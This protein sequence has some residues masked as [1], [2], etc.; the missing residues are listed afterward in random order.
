[1]MI[2][3]TDTK[4][5]EDPGYHAELVRQGSHPLLSYLPR[6]VAIGLGLTGYLLMT[7]CGLERTYGCALR[8]RQRYYPGWVCASLAYVGGVYVAWFSD[9]LVNAI[10]NTTDTEEI[11][12]PA[13]F[14]LLLMLSGGVAVSKNLTAYNA[15]SRNS[16][17]KTRKG[18]GIKAPQAE[19][20][21]EEVEKKNE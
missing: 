14:L 7:L 12:Y 9:R 11:A 18:K 13:G 3:A 21:K 16:K 10:R 20:E 5:F 15:S 19:S 4:I 17:S 2:V 1:M 8:R 6:K